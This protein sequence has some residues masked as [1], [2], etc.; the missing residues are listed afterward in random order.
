MS[1][2]RRVILVLAAVVVLGGLGGCG[3]AAAT[4]PAVRREMTVAFTAEQQEQ[5]RQVDQRSYV[6][7]AGDVLSVKDLLNETLEQESILVLPDGSATFF[8]LD[9]VRVAGMTLREL[10]NLLTAEYAKEFRDPKVTVAVRQIGSSEIYILGEVVD[11]GAYKWTP[12]GFSLLS[13]IAQAGG[14]TNV[15]DQGSVVLVRASSQGYLCREIDLRTVA[16]GRSFDPVILDV[17]PRDVIYVS[18]TKIG[19]FA[20]FTKGLVESLLTYTG[21]AVDIKY[22]MSGDTFRR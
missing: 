9:Q 7:H 3:G 20:V 18:R 19:D 16:D 4:G 6:I 2:M 10:D 11:P 1:V 14:F 21:V 17:R 5:L 8:G 12:T 15:A 13:V 22:L